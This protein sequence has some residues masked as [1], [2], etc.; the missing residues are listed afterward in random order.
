MSKKVNKKPFPPCKYSTCV[1]AMP[2]KV[3]NE[4]VCRALDDN[5]FRHADGTEYMCP[6]YK[7]DKF[8]ESE[9]DKND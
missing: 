4:F 6:F 8:S 7:P 2:S 5:E 3:F 9:V 1:N